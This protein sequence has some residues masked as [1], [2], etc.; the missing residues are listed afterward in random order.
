MSV[1][2]AMSK[3]VLT[4][5]RHLL[6]Y[7]SVVFGVIECGLSPITMSQTN[8]PTLD[9]GQ[10]EALRVIHGTTMGTPIQIV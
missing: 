7:H 4:E 1:L 9:R 8:T 2:R 10:N 6:L 3:E 5:P